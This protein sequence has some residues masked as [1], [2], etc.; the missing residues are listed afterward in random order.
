MY[1]ELSEAERFPLL[2]PRGRQYLQAMRQ[3]AHAPMW[4]WPNGEQLNSAGLER[5][6]RFAEQLTQ[7]DLVN[8]WAEPVWLAAFA[9]RCLQSVP[10]YRQRSRP[11]AAFID[12]P[13]CRRA[14]L[15]PR[16]WLFVP[17]DEPL[18]EVIVFSSSGTTGEPTRTPHHPFSAACGV[19]LLEQALRSLHGISLPRGVDQTAIANVAAYPG[20]FTTAI[21][22]A[23]L[24]EAGCLRVNLDPSAWRHP[25]DRRLYLDAWPSTVWLGDPIAFGALEQVPLRHRP[26]AI[27]SSIMHLPEGYGRRLSERYECP[28]LDIYAMTE[29][30]II[31][32][33]DSA[34]AGEHR[35][36]PP[37]L[38]VEILDET[39]QRCP[40][41]VRGE[42]TLTGGRNPF[43]PLL[44]YR[45]GDFASWDTDRDGSRIL[46]DLIG[47]E[48]IEYQAESG[49]IV[50]QMEIVRLMRQYPVRKFELREL[51]NGYELVLEGDVDRAAISDEFQRLLGSRFLGIVARNK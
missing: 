7:L 1:P 15:A 21:V 47:R 36:L 29:A 33:R 40:R 17:D 8:D 30:G 34:S 13:T 2:T 24:E 42:I 51:S 37:D 19:P 44:R 41:G 22:V 12:L 18:D 32:V 45:T 23:Y 25:E 20:A 16:P 10:F 9:D 39:G 31:A 43:L 5:V 46:R 11:G 4:N 6:R 27:I 26:Q 35:I 38:F 14:D 49:Q 3:H 28:V 50:H 48:P